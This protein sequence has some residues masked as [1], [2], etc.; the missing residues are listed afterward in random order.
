[1]AGRWSEL[2]DLGAILPDTLP[3]FAMQI[4]SSG[5]LPED[6]RFPASELGVRAVQIGGNTVLSAMVSRFATADV[7][8][9]SV[10]GFGAVLFSFPAR[11]IPLDGLDRLSE[12]ARGALSEGSPEV[13][14]A[15]V[16]L[17][18]SLGSL[19]LDLSVSVLEQEVTADSFWEAFPRERFDAVAAGMQERAVGFV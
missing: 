6:Q 14:G 16:M 15:L 1:M 7:A 10:A 9:D 17:A 13:P 19:R 2:D 5:V 4:G 18:W 3:G 11:V 12:D 8:H